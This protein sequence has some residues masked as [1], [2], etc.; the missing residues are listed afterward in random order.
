MIDSNLD[1]VLEES[2][3]MRSKR[4]IWAEPIKNQ[5]L[6]GSRDNPNTEQ[7]EDANPSLNNVL[8]ETLAKGSKR[9]ARTVTN[10]KRK[11]E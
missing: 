6:T 10:S 7:D 3:T 11:L 2:L 1:N 4:S 8:E 5:E 9:T